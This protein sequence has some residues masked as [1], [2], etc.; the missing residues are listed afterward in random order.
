MSRSKS[1]FALRAI[2][3]IHHTFPRLSSLSLYHCNS[4]SNLVILQKSYI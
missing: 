1:T 2:L 3:S 4:S